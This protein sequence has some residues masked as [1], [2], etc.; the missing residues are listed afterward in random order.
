MAQ[1]SG[2]RFTV[3]GGGIVGVC[4]ALYLQRAGFTVSL[5]EKG[6]PGRAA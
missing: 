3:I 4:C 6:A 5:I 2:S 1:G